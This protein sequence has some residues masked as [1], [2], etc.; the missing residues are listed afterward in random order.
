MGYNEIVQTITTVGFPIFA[1]V[2]VFKVMVDNERRHEEETRKLADSIN[3]LRMTLTLI[4]EKLKGVD[5][6]DD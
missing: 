1:S 3:D 4:M 2:M 6:N 5:R